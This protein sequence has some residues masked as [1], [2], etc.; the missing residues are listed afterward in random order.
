MILDQPECAIARYNQ[1]GVHY[2]LAADG[3]YRVRAV[4]DPLSEE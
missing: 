1:M 4:I 2:N 3:I